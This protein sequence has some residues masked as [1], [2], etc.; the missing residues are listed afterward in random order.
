MD[1]NSNPQSWSVAAI[2]ALQEEWNPSHFTQDDEV[3][4]AVAAE[5]YALPVEA[6]R[7][8]LVQ[9]WERQQAR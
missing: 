8:H 7:E 5:L 6:Y 4:Q 9:R 1:L 3:V 2:S